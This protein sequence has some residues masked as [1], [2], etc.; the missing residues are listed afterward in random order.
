MTHQTAACL[1]TS[2]RQ[3]AHRLAPAIESA[4]IWVNSGNPPGAAAE[5]VDIDFYT[6][7]RTVLIGAQ[8]TPVPRFGA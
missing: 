2:D 3:R 8:D 4:S 1:W 5:H 6:R 7:S